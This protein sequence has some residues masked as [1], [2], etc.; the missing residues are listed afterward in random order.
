MREEVGVLILQMGEAGV[1]RTF[2]WAG[3]GLARNLSSHLQRRRGSGL[4]E[5]VLQF[6]GDEKGS[7]PSWVKPFLVQGGHCLCVVRQVECGSFSRV[8]LGKTM[9][10]ASQRMANSRSAAQ[11]VR[12]SAKVELA[13]NQ[14]AEQDVSQ[15]ATLSTVSF[16]R[17]QREA[18]SRRCASRRACTRGEVGDRHQRRGRVR[19][20][21]SST[22]RGSE[23]STRGKRRSNLWR[24][25][26]GRRSSSSSGRRSAWR[27][28]GRRW[29]MRSP[30]LSAQRR[31]WLQR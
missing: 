11:V 15:S 4:G 6:R 19:P 30:R 1:R 26:S 10:H 20:D 14:I 17:W 29:R 18:H 2:I 5:F 31:H 9:R 13:N 24:V 28:L 23:A 7:Q 8:L 3:P 12:Q 27:M 22:P 16:H 21:F 25:G